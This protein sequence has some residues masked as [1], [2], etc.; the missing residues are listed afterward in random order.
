MRTA[1]AVGGPPRARF[2]DVVRAN[3]DRWRRADGALRRA[4]G[5]VPSGPQGP[6][7][8]DWLFQFF[9]SLK[10]LGLYIFVSLFRSG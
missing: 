7:V 4:A 9:F 5:V 2:R 10:V 8:W 3:G 1:R 6:Q